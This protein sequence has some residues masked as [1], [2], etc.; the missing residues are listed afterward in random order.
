V[1]KGGTAISPN[2]IPLGPAPP[3]PSIND[4]ERIAELK[5]LEE[6]K[7]DRERADA[8]RIALLL[9]KYPD[10]AAL[11]KAQDEELEPIRANQR[12][13]KRRIDELLS[14]RKPLLNEAEFYPG[15]RFPLKLKLAFDDNDAQLEGQR[16]IAKLNS[17]DESNVIK[18][19]S[20][21]LEEMSPIWLAKAAR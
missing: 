16:S 4:K 18:K 21:L 10:A 6:R 8:R 7:R 9:K 14:L 17:D 15:Q 11:R 5:L 13:S 1:Q 3:S 20:D 2:G 12:D 19:Y